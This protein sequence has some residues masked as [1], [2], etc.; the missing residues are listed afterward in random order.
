MSEDTT[1]FKNDTIE[2][3]NIET[4][5]FNESLIIKNNTNFYD[6]SMKYNW[7]GNGT[8]QD[9][10]IITDYY[11]NMN[12]TQTAVYIENTD[13]H[14]VLKNC[15]ITYSSCGIVLSQVKN[16]TIQDNTFYN[17]DCGVRLFN[18]QNNIIEGNDFKNINIYSVFINGE[19]YMNRFH[20]NSMFGPGFHFEGDRSTYVS[21]VITK[22]NKVNDKPVLYHSSKNFDNESITDEVG[23]IIISDCSY[24]K[25]SDLS[26]NNTNIGITISYSNH[27]SLNNLNVSQN[28]REGIRIIDSN[29]I[30]ISEINSSYNYHGLY[31][32]GVK[33]STISDN[34]LSNNKDR[35]ISLIFS[36]NNI[37]KNNKISKNQGNGI[38]I[39]SSDSNSIKKNWIVD[40]DKNGINI[41]TFQKA[42]TESINVT[43]YSSNNT[44]LNNIIKSNQ[45]YGVK[46]S[47]NT[48]NNEIYMNSFK[49]NKESNKT[50]DQTTIQAYEE[51]IDGTNNN[52]WNSQ[53]DLGNY[54]E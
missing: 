1:N 17:N 12:E 13:V 50:Y 18:S 14:F 6:K 33:N 40:N 34:I 27:L 37:L 48:E 54:W 39:Y 4:G 53:D 46:L 36:E 20:N 11:F 24:I 42:N 5:H 32:R 51:I 47:Q 43:D 35:G 10:F 44:I 52:H 19:S 41:R 2:I 23:Q 16:G 15:N 22:D 9:P 7:T 28:A 38:D 29:N 30:K 45:E 49:K 3:K 26:I 21:Q 31:L 8:E 25:I